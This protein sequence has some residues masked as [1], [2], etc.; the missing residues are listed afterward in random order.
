MIFSLII[1]YES[2]HLLVP[3][4]PGNLGGCLIEKIARKNAIYYLFL[5]F[6]L[7]TIKVKLMYYFDREL[8]VAKWAT[9]PLIVS[10]ISAI[11]YP[12][13][14]RKTNTYLCYKKMD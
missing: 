2:D 13:F 1:R 8:L 6:G 10:T 14:R 11:L 4:K 5:C 3:D 7:F 12:S 9:F